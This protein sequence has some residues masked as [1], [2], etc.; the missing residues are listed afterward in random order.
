MSCPKQGGP[1][2]AAT[3]QKELEQR[4]STCASQL[5][6]SGGVGGMIL[7]Q[8]LPKTTGKQIFTL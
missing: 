6:G 7:S 8:G 4:F 2:I 3:R 5:L 1:Q